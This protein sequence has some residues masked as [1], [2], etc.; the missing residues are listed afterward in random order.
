MGY[1]GVLVIAAANSVLLFFVSLLA[2]GGN[3]S[4]DGVELVLTVGFSWLALFTVA[5]FL[6]CGRKGG[7]AG[8]M[9]AASALPSAFL[10]ALVLFIAAT[11]LG[12]NA[13]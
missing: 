10:T 5:A 8:M 3:G 11:V 4:A 13:R 2:A 6:V 1:L 7:P 12:V 9:V